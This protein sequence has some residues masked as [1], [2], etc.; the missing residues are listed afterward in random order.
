M[1]VAS[2][3]RPEVAP[4]SKARKLCFCAITGYRL[5]S[6]AKIWYIPH[7]SREEYAIKTLNFDFFNSP[8]YP[9]FQEKVFLVIFAV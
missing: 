8:V 1:K 3:A 2:T 6:I 4:Q 7:S 5:V 9:L